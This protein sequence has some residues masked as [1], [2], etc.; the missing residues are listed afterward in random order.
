MLGLDVFMQ[1]LLAILAMLASISWLTGCAALS[2]EKLMDELRGIATST[3]ERMGTDSLAQFQVGGQAINP[4]IEV[5]AG[6]SYTIRAGYA[7]VA[8][9]FQAA[10]TGK[11][12]RPV[13]SAAILAIYNDASLSASE[14]QR[15]IFALLD[16]S[17]SVQPGPVTP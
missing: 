1:R 7:G 5:S 16:G 8:G 12:D 6:V 3:V 13:D 2:T 14:R 17:R 11:L 9:Q 15:R 10:G 4:A